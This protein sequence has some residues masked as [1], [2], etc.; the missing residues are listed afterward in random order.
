MGGCVHKNTLWQFS[1]YGATCRCSSKTLT[2]LRTPLTTVLYDSSESDLIASCWSKVYYAT[3]SKFEHAYAAPRRSV[4]VSKITTFRG[5]RRYCISN[6]QLEAQ[7]FYAN[8][9]LNYTYELEISNTPARNPSP[10]EP[11]FSFMSPAF[12]SASQ[13]WIHGF[14]LISHSNSQQKGLLV[15]MR[16]IFTTK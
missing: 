9:N 12:P 3:H 16:N 15:I 14:L 13:L 8:L 1:C 11:S 2:G 7:N 6:R 10:S 4:G 5:S